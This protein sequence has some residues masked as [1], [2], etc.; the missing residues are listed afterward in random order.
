MSPVGASEPS[1]ESYQLLVKRSH[2]CLPHHP[3]PCFQGGEGGSRPRSAVQGYRPI[4]CPRHCLGHVFFFFFFSILAFYRS[5][6]HIQQNVRWCVCSSMNFHI[7]NSL[8]YSTPWLTHSITSNPES[9]QRFTLVAIALQAITILSVLIE[10]KSIWRQI[11]HLK[12]NSSVSLNPFTMLCNHA[13]L[14]LAP[15][16]CHHPKIKPLPQEAVPHLQP[17]STQLLETT[18]LLFVPR[19]IY[20]GYFVQGHMQHV[21][22]RVRLLSL[23]VRFSRSTHFIACI[24]APSFVLLNC[25]NGLHFLM[26]SSIDELL[27]LSVYYE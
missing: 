4:W 3:K 15:K 14:C 17:T 16:H 7:L 6:I 18:S 2:A 22:F 21:T 27:S 9:P 19:F 11:N 12:V 20:S 5:T 10:I 23:S 1:S 13:H 8:V 24:R 25:V 26:H